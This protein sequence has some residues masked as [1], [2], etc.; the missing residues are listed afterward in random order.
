MYP[1]QIEIEASAKP[2]RRNGG[3]G[4]DEDELQ[5]DRTD[6]LFFFLHRM[7]VARSIAKF[8]DD[9][10]QTAVSWYPTGERHEQAISCLRQ[11]A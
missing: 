8:P 3:G 10:D 5:A 9:M 4:G 7:P 11:G 2:G 1:R 6:V